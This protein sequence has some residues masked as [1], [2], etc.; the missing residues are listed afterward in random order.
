MSASTSNRATSSLI[1]GAIEV[2]GSRCYIVLLHDRAA[3]KTD[4]FAVPAL[5]TLTLA[6]AVVRW[7]HLLGAPQ[8]LH[9]FPGLSGADTVRMLRQRFGLGADGGGCALGAPVTERLADGIAARVRSVI[10]RQ[11]AHGFVACEE[12]QAALPAAARELARA[13][14]VFDAAAEVIVIDD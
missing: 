14:D 4:I 12:W 6:L 9:F 7:A 13:D 8:T 1:I 5:G 2:A 3:L 10:V 11:I